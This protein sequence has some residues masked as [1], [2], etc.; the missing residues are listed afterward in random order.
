MTTSSKTNKKA[1]KELRKTVHSKYCNCFNCCHTRA[2]KIV[3][4]P[5]K[6]KKIEKINRKEIHSYVEWQKIIAVKVNEIIN[7]LNR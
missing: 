7:C 3:N 6:Q 2:L 5:T 1:I 4:K